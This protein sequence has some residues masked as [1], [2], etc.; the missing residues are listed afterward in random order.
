MPVLYCQP[1]NGLANRMM[2]MLSAMRIARRLNYEFI[3]IWDREA[4]V[5]D[6][7]MGCSF[8]DLF[9]SLDANSKKTDGLNLTE[10]S[11]ELGR[12]ILDTSSINGGDIF[13]KGFH[14][15]FDLNDILLFNNDPSYSRIITKEIQSEWRSLRPID[16]FIHYVEQD[17]F[18]L[19]IHIRRSTHIKSVNPDFAKDWSVPSDA[20]LVDLLIQTIENEN[21]KRIFLCSASM[22]TI[23][24]IASHLRSY[25]LKVSNTSNWDLDVS[26]V[27]DAFKDF[28]TLTS[29]RLMFRNREST[30]SA[31][32]SLLGST[33][34]FVYSDN[35]E[36]TE[37]VPLIFNGAGL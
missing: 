26:S 10:Y 34:E 29:C 36:L 28:L 27:Q 6:S 4:V 15:I 14:F 22:Q 5:D 8:Q 2:F 30:F 16:N 21:I 37:L 17:K 20:R 32:P 24:F 12:N 1:I 9:E 23:D 35:G 25:D 31:L 7:T 13:I 33:K 3:P 19:G 18:D 11:T